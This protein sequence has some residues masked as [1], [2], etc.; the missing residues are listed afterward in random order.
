MIPGK[1][2]LVC[3]IKCPLLILCIN[4]TFMI[5]NHFALIC[6]KSQ[7]YTLQFIIQI[8]LRSQI[9]C[10]KSRCSIFPCIRMLPFRFCT[11]LIHSP[12][13]GIN[14][15]IGTSNSK[16]FRLRLHESILLFPSLIKTIRRT[17]LIDTQQVCNP[18]GRINFLL[19]FTQFSHL[20]KLLPILHFN[21]KNPNRNLPFENNG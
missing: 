19:I 12:L 11:P 2:I 18:I 20:L 13:N 8:H 21:T 17:I 16:L 1:Q 10:T 9:P 4:M 5:S 3:I 15:M 14:K 6:R 7:L